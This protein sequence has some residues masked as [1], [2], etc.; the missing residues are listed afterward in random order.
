MTYVGASQGM[1]TVMKDAETRW[2]QKIRKPIRFY[3]ITVPQGPVQLDGESCEDTRAE[4]SMCEE[5]RKRNVK[6]R[7]RTLKQSSL[8]IARYWTIVFVI[9]ILV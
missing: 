4:D 8:G 1:L 5:R 7:K 6:R 2:R 9:C 3:Q